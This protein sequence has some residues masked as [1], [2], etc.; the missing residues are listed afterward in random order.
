MLLYNLAGPGAAAPTY[1]TS[2]PLVAQEFVL[3]PA[4]Y[5]GYS[6]RNGAGAPNLVAAPAGTRLA[7]SQNGRFAIE[8]ADL[9]RRQPKFFFADP[10]QLPQWNK[11]LARAGSEF[12]LFAEPTRTVVFTL[13]G[14]AAT[15]TLVRVRQANL[16]AR[17]SAG[18]V[19]MTENCD[20]AVQN[21]IGS[22][23][24]PR[25]VLGRKPFLG[26]NATERTVFGEYHLANHLVRAAPLADLPAAAPARDAARDLIAQH[27]GE[28]IHTLANGG[29]LHAPNIAAELQAVGLNQHARPTAVGQGLY[30]T[31]LGTVHPHLPTGQQ[32]FDFANNRQLD[33]LVTINGRVWGFHWGG[34][35]AIDGTD[36]LTLENYARTAENS[37]GNA[38]HL[39]YFQAYG[40]GPGQDW[41]TRWTTPSAHGKQFANALTM[42]VEPEGVRGLANWVPA[43]KSNSAAV[44]TAATNAALTTA[45]LNGLNYANVH[46]YAAELVAEYADPNRRIGWIQELNARIAAPPAWL[47]DETRALLQHVRNEMVKVK[48]GL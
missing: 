34:V 28:D 39:G 43:E 29:V 32:V 36:Y 6:F 27:Y 1:T 41:H 23:L 44:G 10:A 25:P 48:S 22:V 47:D 7:V 46:I 40:A 24:Q 4:A 14:A 17:N 38:A 15:T 9:T 30:S 35:V 37:A 12:Q 2:H 8:A 20:V 33:H 45:L 5:V 31:S 13:P 21:V 42:V 26:S 11:A 3:D 16:S 19:T 18:G